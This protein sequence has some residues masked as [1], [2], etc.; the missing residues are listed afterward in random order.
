M[1]N[2]DKRRKNR[3]NRNRTQR[4]YYNYFKCNQGFRG[5]TDNKRFG[6]IKNNQME[7]VELINILTPYMKLTGCI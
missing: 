2:R 6:N 5:K 4:F 1:D 7:L 3:D